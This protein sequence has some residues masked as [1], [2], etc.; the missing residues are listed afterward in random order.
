MGNQGQQNLITSSIQE[1]TK[2]NNRT[3]SK[4][5]KPQKNLMKLQTGYPQ[6]QLFAHNSVQNQQNYRQNNS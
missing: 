6:K 1:K 3:E 2:R 4:I 5:Q